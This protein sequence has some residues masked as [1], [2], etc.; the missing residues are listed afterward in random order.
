MKL[1][2]M[3]L[4]GIRFIMIYAAILTMIDDDRRR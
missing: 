2:A 3:V 1:A 4:L